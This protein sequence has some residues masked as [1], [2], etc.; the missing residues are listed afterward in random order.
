MY[1]PSQPRET[2]VTL[3]KVLK[4][5]ALSWAALLAI[6]NIVLVIALLADIKG[7][8]QMPSG[9]VFVMFLVLLSVDAVLCMPALAAEWWRSMRI[10]KTKFAVL[11][12]H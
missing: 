5:F 10:A 1:N 11:E 6:P 9:D 3:N 8:A 12:R 2:I 7:L 4:I